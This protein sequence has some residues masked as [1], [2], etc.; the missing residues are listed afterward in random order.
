ME[1]LVTI[2]NGGNQVHLGDRISWAGL[3]EE[4]IAIK[5]HDVYVKNSAGGS[6]RLPEGIQFRV[7]CPGG[8]GHEDP[9]AQ[10]V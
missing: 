3:T 5:G 9:P 8:P 6:V 10:P 4:V 1:R 2:G 7:S